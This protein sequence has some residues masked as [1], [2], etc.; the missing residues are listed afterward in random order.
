M[1]VNNIN[2]ND[3]KI[4]FRELSNRRKDQIRENYKNPNNPIAFSAPGN[5]KRTT[6]KPHRIEGIAKTLEN[7][8]PYTLHREFHKPR[9]K[10]PFYVYER[11]AQV[12]MDLI[13]VSEF[14]DANDGVTFLLIAI[15]CFTKYAWVKA[16]KKKN[17]VESL[18]AMKEILHDITN[19]SE[20]GK[21]RKPKQI[22]FDKGTEF[23]NN[24]VVKFLGEQQIKIVHPNSE[25][26][27]AIVERFNRSF[28]NLIYKFKTEN[29][30]HRYI[31]VLDKLMYV[32]NS[33]GHRTLKYMSPA[34]AEKNENQKKVFAAHNHRYSKLEEKRKTPKFKVGQKVRIKTLEGK[35]ARGYNQTFSLEQFEIVEVKTNMP[36]PMYIIKSLNDG[37]IVRGGFYA[38][39]L[40]PIDTSDNVFK[41]EKV[42]KKRRLRGKEQLFVKW[43]GFDENHNSW[44]N[45]E[46]ITRN[47]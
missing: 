21:S 28:Q 34:N 30:T 8:D 24:L 1:A 31:D 26:K 40:Q 16:M 46:E 35:F 43:Q 32:Y 33:R 10:N 17:A 38:E 36:I 12:Q 9:V 14:K 29:Q 45:S 3:V 2:K 6:N 13:D 47:Y 11:R 23:T 41:I 7:V 4:N 15:D 19:N 39:E 44:I 27:A 20:D 37:D 18:S 22:F 42:L 25:L 5:I